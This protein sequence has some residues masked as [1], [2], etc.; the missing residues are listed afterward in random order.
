[1]SNQGQTRRTFMRLSGVTLGTLA[2]SS[3]PTSHDKPSRL[4]IVCIGGHPGDPEFGCGGTLAR[5]SN[6]G[7]RVTVIYLTRGE[8]GDPSKTHQESAILRTREAETACMV[9]SAKPL[10]FGQVD[11]DTSL[12]N[13]SIAAMR[14]LIIAQKPD[15]LFTHWPVDAHPDHQVAGLLG[16]NA[17]V[18]SGQ[19]FE[20][21]YYEVNTGSET[22][23]FVPTDYVRI[24]EFREKKKAAMF[25]HESQSPIELYNTLF[26]TL[27]EF[28]GYQCGVK[29]AEAFIRF[30]SKTGRATISGL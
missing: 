17:W 9:L 30:K 24:T 21:Y 5:Y 29:A 15:I 2:T 28:R 1:M 26:K 16:F 23:A 6:Q 12:S 11:A 27:E 10:F 3:S 25:A 4:N 8:A 22:M 14:D 19:D 13:T 18:K 20:L 7:H